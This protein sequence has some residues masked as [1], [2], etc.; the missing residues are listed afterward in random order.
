MRRCVLIERD[1]LVTLLNFLAASNNVT[2]GP[3]ASLGIYCGCG[4]ARTMPQH[5]YPFIAAWTT[6]FMFIRPEKCFAFANKMRCLL[7]AVA[8]RRKEL[9]TYK[10]VSIPEQV[11]PVVFCVHGGCILQRS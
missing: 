2:I 3:S 11:L 1:S 6:G 4:S 10:A 9:A 8:N 5:H 7:S